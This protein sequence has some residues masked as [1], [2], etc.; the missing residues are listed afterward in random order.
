M[1]SQSASQ[2]EPISASEIFPSVDNQALEVP[3]GIPKFTYQSLTSPTSFRLLQILSDGGQDILRCR[4]FDA[5]LAAQ[6]TPRYIALSY[7]WQEES[8]P[9][10]FR[11]VLINDKY[12]NVSLNL[13]NFLQNYRETAG[14]RIIWI[15]Q[16]CI[17]Q[18]DT[19]EC[20]QQIGQMCEIYQRASMDLFWIGEPGE[21]EEAVLDLLSS[22]N[23][24]ETYLLESGSSRPGISALLNPIFMRTIG[25][26][27]H[28]D[29]IWG[30][31]M[32]FISR[33]AFQRAWIIQEVA[34]SRK[35]AIFSGLLM[36]PFDVVGG[37]ATFLVES[38]WIKVF[39]QMYTVSGA[40]SFVMGMMNCRVR[41]QEG[42]HQSLDLLLASTRRF[43]A[44]KPVDKIF[45]LI[46]LA[47]SGG[48]EALPPALRPDY[49]KSVVEVF[50]DVTLHLI[51]QGSLDI[52]S[53]V[54]DVKF[55][56]IHQLPSWVPDYSVHQVASILFMPP[57]PGWFTLYAAAA[58]RDVSVQH[59]PSDPNI[60][61]LSAYKVDTITKIGPIAEQSIYSTLEKWASMVDFSAP[62]PIVNGN[63]ASMI[64]AFWRTLVGNIGIGA[65]CYP[66]SEDWLY[67]FAAFAL[68][69]REELRNHFANSPDTQSAVVESPSSTPG[70]DSILL[71]LK[72]HH[73]E[74]LDQDGG[75]YESTMHHTTDV[76]CLKQH[77]KAALSELSKRFPGLKGRILLL[78]DPPGHLAIS[79]NDVNAIPFKFF[80]QRTSFSWTYSQLKSQG[81]PAHAFVDASFDLHYQL[82]G[83]EGIPAFEVHVRLI[84]GGLLLGIYGHHS[85][86][87]AGR[88]DMVIRYFAGLTKDPQTRLDV[89]I[90]ARLSDEAIT[91]A[92]VPTVP[93]LNELL[94]RC[95][96]Y[97]LLSSPLGPTQFRAPKTDKLPKNTGCIFVIQNQTVRDLK[98]KL[99]STRLTDLKHQPST[100]TCLAAITW[101]HVTKARIASLSSGMTMAEDARLMISV[102]WRRRISNDAITSSSGNAIALPIASINKSIIQAACSED[103][104]IAYSALA[105]LARAIDD[106]IISVNEDF[107]AARTALFHKIPDPRFIGLDFDL[108]DP[109]EFYL[110]TWWHFGTRTHWNLPGLDKQDF[111]RGITPDAAR[112]A[113]A[114]FGTGAGLVLPEA[115]ATKF[116]VLITLDVGAME[117]LCSS[118]SWQHWAETPGL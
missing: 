108:S 69:A 94:S 89:T 76:D 98:D 55:R 32:Q 34:V 96:E 14:E 36:L 74:G 53:G 109:L 90:S 12:L 27:E 97:R 114:G 47:E 59:S 46:N 65:S 30:S 77:L 26:P 115:D 25:L 113:Q 66:V 21:N 37:A 28:D 68:Q 19:D 112:R 104:R 16:I 43:K 6:G 22:L 42:E 70:I 105:A 72:D 2:R 8:L 38:S 106:A 20:V 86:F 44:T 102:D 4:M 85:I 67:N 95:P 64:D 24:L 60:L 58:G 3:Q 13:W 107:V 117:H 35:A 48:N 50:R 99:A 62:Y 7:T 103:Q 5:D 23:R 118:R 49:R 101:A 100:F 82:E 73:K 61:T 78:T 84:D 10:I 15:D 71:L 39:H 29:L 87:D 1:S 92:H 17:N 18:D 54:E 57:R 91:S 79:T 111:V 63:P 93:D 110:N 116:E 75:L 33:T 56:Q 40:A 88:M 80:D 51:R 52:L 81:F 31:L 9:K 83:G 45:A 41:H 11:P